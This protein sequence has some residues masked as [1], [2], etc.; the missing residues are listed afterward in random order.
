MSCVL[1][2]SNIAFRPPCFPHQ[3][4]AAG[5]RQVRVFPRLATVACFPALWQRWLVSSRAL[6]TVACFPAL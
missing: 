3:F 2:Q 5:C 4:A 1:D 6:T